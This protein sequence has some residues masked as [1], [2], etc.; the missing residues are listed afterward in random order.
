MKK[1]I[2]KILPALVILII[3]FLLLLGYYFFGKPPV[4]SDI[5]WGVNFSQK[6]TRDFGLDWKETY[7]A[8]LDDLGVKKLKVAAHWDL[9]EFEK[10]EYY[11]DDLDWQIA[12]AAK[13]NAEILLVIGMKT[14][15]WPE[16]HIP[17]WAK[18]MDKSNQQAEIL[19]MLERA[20]LRYKDYKNIWAWQV[21]NEPFFPF[22]DCPWADKEFLKKEVGLVRNLD[23]LKRPVVISDSGEGSL[24]ISAAKIGDIVGTTMYRKVWVHQIGIYLNYNYF[25]SQNFYWW[26]AKIIKLLFDKDVICAELQT[27]PWGPKLLYDTSLEEQKKTMDLER[28]QK[29]IEFAKGTGLKGFYLWGTEWM[30]W[31]K[32]KNNQPDI[33]NEA[34]KLFN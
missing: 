10:D 20:V 22:G 28:F 15:R 6:H 24:W 31:M 1:F 33:W 27:E 19:K 16:C 26:K 2:K 30:Y 13:R 23:S 5:K 25:F 11:F 3:L 29:N 4:A 8:I 7:T 18:G 9:L 32:E 14:P 34:K 21:E 12:E 17:T